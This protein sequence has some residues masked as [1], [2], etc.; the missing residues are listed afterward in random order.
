MKEQEQVDDIQLNE[1]EEE[2]LDAVWKRIEEETQ[3]SKE[4]KNN[5]EED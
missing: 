2:I 1:E 4:Q 5:T 3:R